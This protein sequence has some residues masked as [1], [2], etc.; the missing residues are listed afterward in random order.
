MTG[1]PGYC[2]PDTMTL[3]TARRKRIFPFPPHALSSRAY[4]D[5]RTRYVDSDDPSRERTSG[6]TRS[7]AR[8]RAVPLNPRDSIRTVAYARA[9]A[10]C[11]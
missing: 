11:S 10:V 9:A 1:M 4:G 3:L 8:E 7:L 2:E 6:F 5:N